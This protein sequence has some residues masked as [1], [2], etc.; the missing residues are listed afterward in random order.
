MAMITIKESWKQDECANDDHHKI[1]TSY[2]LQ[3][4]L[5]LTHTETVSLSG[6]KFI[7][8]NSKAKPDTD[9]KTVSREK[10]KLCKNLHQLQI[11]G[12]KI[13]GERKKT[14]AEGEC[15]EHDTHIYI[16]GSSLGNN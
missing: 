1:H 8:F 14:E 9:E 10:A 13:V 11:W 7:W 4:L 12:E 6:C 16:K 15:V 3:C 5:P 2:F